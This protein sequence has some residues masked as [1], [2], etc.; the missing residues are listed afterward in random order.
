[1]QGI[2]YLLEDYY[3]NQFIYAAGLWNFKLRGCHEQNQITRTLNTDKVAQNHRLI[4]KSLTQHLV[5]HR[6]ENIVPQPQTDLSTGLY[7]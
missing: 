5:G 6:I 1:M 4:Y 3:M 2:S 7:R